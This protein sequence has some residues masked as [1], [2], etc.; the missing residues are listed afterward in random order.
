[1]LIW[2]YSNFQIYLNIKNQ[3]SVKKLSSSSSVSR[4]LSSTLEELKLSPSFFSQISNFYLNSN[5]I[6]DNYDFGDNISIGIEY[7]AYERLY[8]RCGY[9]N[10]YSSLGLGID[11]YDFYCNCLFT[12][13]Y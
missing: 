5:Y 1:M 3:S 11:L 6:I 7:F 2:T 10:E 13:F 9:N 8:L 4:S 12:V